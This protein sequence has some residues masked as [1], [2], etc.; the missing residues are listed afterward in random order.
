M[1]L[2]PESIAR[3]RQAYVALY[4]AADRND[5]LYQSIS[6]GRRYVG[7]EHWL[8]LFSD[9]LETIFDHVGAAPV[10]LDSLADE[11]VGERIDLIKDHYDARRT[12]L[13][14]GQGGVPYKPAPPDR[15]YLTL[16]EWQAR[17]AAGPL[18][19]VTPFA[20]PEAAN[21]VD[22]GGRRGRN[23]SAEAQ[24]R[25]HQCLRRGDR[26]YRHAAAGG[27]A[28]RRRLLERG[29][30]RPHRPGARRPRHGRR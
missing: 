7:M 15:L 24:C 10:V 29:L 8:A 28:R 19:R 25:R 26:P 23:F 2:V 1:Q 3:F 13:E 20:Q 18:A 11:A 17:L 27:P 14:A 4:G 21:V 30:A 22:L 9:G 16:A 6:E 5:L 12:A